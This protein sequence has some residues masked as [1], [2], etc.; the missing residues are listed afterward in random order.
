MTEEERDEMKR[1]TGA[2]VLKAKKGFHY[3]PVVTNDFG[4]LYPSCIISHNISPDRRIIPDSPIDRITEEQKEHI[5]WEETD[6]TKFHYVYLKADC[7]ETKWKKENKPKNMSSEEEK[8]WNQGFN[9][10]Q[11]TVRGGRGILPQIEMYL[12]ES[13]KRAKRRKAKAIS[14]NNVFMTGVYDGQQLAYKL[15]ANSLYGLMGAATSDICCKPVAASITATGRQLLQFA[16]DVSKELYP[17]SE[18]I[19]GDTDSIMVRYPLENYDPTKKYTTDD[20]KEAMN[21]QA[22]DCGLEVERVVSE[23]L[24]YPHVLEME[25][26]FHPFILLS[27][28]RYAAIQYDKDMRTHSKI[29]YSGIVMTRRDN[30]PIV[31]KIFGK[32]LDIIMFE[33]DIEKA[34]SFIQRECTSLLKGEYDIDDL[35]ISV[36]LKKVKKQKQAQHILAERI[37]K[38]DPGNAPQLSD[39]VVYVFIKLKKEEER[40]IL[41][42][43]N[44][45]DVSGYGVERPS[46]GTSFETMLQ[47]T[48]APTKP[49]IKKTI[50][51]GYKIE[52][53]DYIRTHPEIEID[54]FHYLTNQIMK[55]ICDLFKT[56]YDDPERVI[57]KDILDSHYMNS[58]KLRKITDFFT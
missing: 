35:C 16:M 9:H 1:Y 42:S 27:K 44:G 51:V 7:E 50:D 39:R 10:Y 26:I 54:C 15:C 13:R 32:A 24:P 2:V 18:V 31:K 22:R 37:V 20:E 30:A 29:N 34:V 14:E 45:V 25:K 28:K 4:S 6:G 52:T 58:N 11:G 49:K 33:H 56:V 19:Y 43:I 55:P 48:N 17:E 36:T 5:Q 23:R 41:A 12:L 47:R 40:R 21:I 57:F 53:P 3:Y 46:L 38:R 8:E